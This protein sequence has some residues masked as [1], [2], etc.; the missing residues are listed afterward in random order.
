MNKVDYFRKEF[1][2]RLKKILEA[3]QMTQSQ[4]AEKIGVDKTV[5]SKYIT[6]PTR[7]P[8]MDTFLAICDALEVSTDYFLN[9]SITFN[10]RNQL[11]NDSRS[12][13]KAIAII[14]ENDIYQCDAYGDHKWFSAPNKAVSDFINEIF[15]YKDTKYSRR[16]DIIMDLIEHYSK[17]YD[18]YEEAKKTEYDTED[19]PF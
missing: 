9:E 11:P 4:L 17:K 7:I 3:K 14:V 6:D 5:I 16:E 15:R 12:I 8:K 10:K 1:G 18:E 13:L 2:N 19:L